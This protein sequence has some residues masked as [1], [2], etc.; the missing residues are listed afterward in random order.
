MDGMDRLLAL[1]AVLQ[2]R[3]ASG[4][5][6]QQQLENVLSGRLIVSVSFDWNRVLADLNLEFDDFIKAARLPTPA[7]RAAATAVIEKQ[8]DEARPRLTSPW[9][10]VSGALR[11]SARTEMMTL[12]LSELLRPAS[13]AML[14]M[15]DRALARLQLL[16]VAAALAE[17]RAERGNYPTSLAE[18]VPQILAA[19]PNDLNGKHLMYKPANGGYLLY[20]VGNNATDDGGSN[21]HMS[22]H[23]GHPVDEMSTE[24]MESYSG[25]ILADGD[26]WS[27]LVPRP[28]FAM[29]Q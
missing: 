28:Q 12:A 16:G 4:N 3:R 2:G 23:E 8:L 18:L 20:S 7:E 25:R 10:W 11:R 6:Q 24:E 19:V 22:L 27:I 21:G 29:P 15:Q 14:M 17:Y 13:Q 9:A 5:N 1:D 26:D